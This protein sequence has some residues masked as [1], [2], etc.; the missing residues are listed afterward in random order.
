MAAIES[1]I[2]DS[3]VSLIRTD[4]PSLKVVNFDKVKLSIEDFQAHEIPACQIYDVSQTNTHVRGQKE[5]L[6]GL[7]IEI[8]MR[9]TVTGTVDQKALWN[10][11]RDIEL[12]IWAQP[13]LNVTQVIHAIYKSN[14]TDL[15]L[16]EP[17]YIARMDLD[18]KYRDDLTGSC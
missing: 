5:V 12:V 3:L 6:W 7:A 16:L 10:L 8:I 11:R 18:V 17:Y 9:P 4:V 13:N 1:I 14:I 15:H 2:A